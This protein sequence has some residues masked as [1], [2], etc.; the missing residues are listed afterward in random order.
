MASKLS[1][2]HKGLLDAHITKRVGQKPYE[3]G[4][5]GTQSNKDFVYF[6]L[7]DNLNNLI[8]FKNLPLSEFS[9]NETNNNIEFYPGN[10]IRNLGF[11][12]GVFTVSYN[13][14]RRL[15]GDEA[16]VLVKTKDSENIIPK[17]A[18]LS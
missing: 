4:L 10:H 9:I 16:S 7:S 11:E 5:W 12:S 14:L 1:Q 6:E 3:N 17:T 18:K 2:K 13:F 8:E 15:A